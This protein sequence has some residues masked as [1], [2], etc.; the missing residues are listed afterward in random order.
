MYR[1]IDSNLVEIHLD[2]GEMKLLR[3]GDV[4]IHRGTMH[5]WRN[6]SDTEA[7]RMVLV[8]LPSEDITVGGK[9]VAG[10]PIG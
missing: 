2:S 7:A 9:A 8:L 1:L 6:P 5:S 4:L 3:T 10:K